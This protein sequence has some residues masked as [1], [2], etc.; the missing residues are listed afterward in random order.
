MK[1]RAGKAMEV[2]WAQDGRLVGL[3]LHTGPI[4][5]SYSQEWID[6]GH[7][8]SPFSLPL[9]SRPQNIL[10]QG[11]H[12][13]PGFIADALPDAWGTKVAEAVFAKNK[14]GA[15]TAVKMLAW[16]G[17]RAMGGLSFAPVISGPEE[18]ENWLNQISVERLASEASE[19]LRGRVEA[20]AAMAAAGG[21][22]GGA[23][24]KALVIEHS[25]GTLS[26]RRAPQ[27][28][29]EIPSLIKLDVPE[30]HSECRVE[31]AYGLMAQA[32]GISVP[33]SRLIENGGGGHLLIRRFD[34]RDDRRLHLHS[35]C[36]MWHRP[37][38][39]LDYADL[40]RAIARLGL[41]R[42]QLLQAARRMIFNLLAANLDDHGRNHSFLYD[43]MTRQWELSPAYDLT[44][45]PGVLSR[46]MT[47]AGEIFPSVATL[48]QFLGSVAI[49]DS[50]VDQLIADVRGAIHRWPE[51]AHA[52]KLTPSKVAEI[53][54][55]HRKILGRVGA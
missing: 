15:V 39:G 31:Y 10:A 25:D 22:A 13:L 46:G 38:S 44:F 24:P 51:F 35:L 52:A 19:I 41:P 53:G 7:N 20:I 33:V 30:I 21:T 40:F 34:W 12:G 48:R 3:L 47:I 43:V 26:L 1:R 27:A 8:L 55:E 17:D 23:H 42:A 36:G 5:F 29:G 45:A 11:C 4:Y 6:T 18:K 49:S 37:K 28:V 50:E 2:R 54:A 14:W 16:I 9:D 32:A